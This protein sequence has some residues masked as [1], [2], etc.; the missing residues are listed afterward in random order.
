M[1]RYIWII[2]AITVLAL[3]LHCLGWF[4]QLETEKIN[5]AISLLATLFSFLSGFIF[6]IYT[7]ASEFAI[8]KEVDSDTK[9]KD[10]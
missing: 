10:N 5:R 3:V 1:K 9:F 2:I 8:L 6:I 7:K 4:Y